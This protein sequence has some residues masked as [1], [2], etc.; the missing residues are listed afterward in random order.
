MITLDTQ[1]SAQLVTIMTEKLAKHLSAGTK[2]VLLVNNL[3]GFSMLELAL[4]TREV[5]KSPMAAQIS[6]LIGPATLVSALDMKGFSLTVLQM[7]A[8]FLEALKAPVE[9]LGWTPIHAVEPVTSLTS[10]RVVI[11]LEFTPSQDEQVG[12][13]VARVAQKLIDLEVG[14]NA[15]DAKVGDGDTGSTFAAGAR[16][17]K[18]ALE[19][20]QLPQGASLPEALKQGLE[21]MKHYGGAQ[22]GHRTLVEALVAGKS[23]AEAAEATAQGAESTAQMQ[24]ARAGRSSYLNQQTLDGVKDPG[25]YAVEKVFAALGEARRGSQRTCSPRRRSVVF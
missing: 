18:S 15:L 11:Q 9:V 3:G 25:A 8:A 20:Q 13:V 1:N 12:Q 23:L 5:L 16:K 14:L 2:A 22:I 21:Q 24:S 4:V 19:A 17:V 6:H 7:E 10:E